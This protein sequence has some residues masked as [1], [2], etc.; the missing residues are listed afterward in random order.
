MA[1][2]LLE[3]RAREIENSHTSKYPTDGHSMSNIQLGSAEKHITSYYK[4]T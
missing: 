3:K 2:S 4:A 1:N